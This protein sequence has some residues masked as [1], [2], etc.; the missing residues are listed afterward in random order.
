MFTR[1]LPQ[2]FNAV[3]RDFHSD[4]E[5]FAEEMSFSTVAPLR[6][7]RAFL[8][9]VKKSEKKNVIF[10]NSV[11]ASSQI[12][13]MMANQFNAY[14][15]AKAA[16]NMFVYL[17]LLEFSNNLIIFVICPGSPASGVLRSNTRASPPLLST[18]VC[19]VSWSSPFR[20]LTSMIIGWTQTDLGAPLE[21]WMSKYAPQVPHLTP[22]A[23]GA[24]VIKI[25]EALT[26][27]KTACL[28][29]ALRRHQSA[30]VNQF[31]MC[32]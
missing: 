23:A 21:E 1:F 26:I 16:L 3:T 10:I 14:S 13:Y 24:G 29:L 27:E 31:P 18:L 4:L 17:Y 30:L 15:V 19:N 22:D 2:N 6:V 28:F 12:S 32:T 11:L 25:S 5:A 8:P 20:F 7:S 9:L